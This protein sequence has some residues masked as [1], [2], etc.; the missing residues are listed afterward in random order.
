MTSLMVALLTWIAAHSG[1]PVP[2]AL[3]DVVAVT[4]ADFQLYLCERIEHC[5]APR[6]R[7]EILTIFDF[8]S[9]TIYVVQGFDP[10]NLEHRSTMVRPLVHFLQA[11]ARPRRGCHGVL[12]QEARRIQDRW[13]TAHG[14]PPRPLT[15]LGML[16]ESCEPGP[17]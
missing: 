9:R 6:L 16:L 13:R 8:E 10:G 15:P 1:Y 17:T 7:A 2:D 12:V 3:P 4:Q 14:L 11:L 5:D